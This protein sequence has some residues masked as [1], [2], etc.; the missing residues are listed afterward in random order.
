MTQSHLLALKK[1]KKALKTVIKNSQNDYSDIVKAIEDGCPKLTNIIF[2]FGHIVYGFSRYIEQL[3]MVMKAK[4]DQRKRER[5]AGRDEKFEDDF[6]L[7]A[8]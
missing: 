7:E 3:Q 1:V 5:V 6:D 8:D 4:T 2:T